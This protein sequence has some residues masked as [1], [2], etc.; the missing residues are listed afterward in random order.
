MESLPSTAVHCSFL[1]GRGLAGGKVMQRA[2]G[3]SPRHRN[4]IFVTSFL[5]LAALALSARAAPPTAEEREPR[6]LGKAK[7]G[8]RAVVITPEG[9][10]VLV[11]VGDGDA[12]VWDCEKGREVRTFEHPFGFQTHALA[13]APDGRHAAL[14]CSEGA[15]SLRNL[16]SGEVIRD[17]KGH[18]GLIQCLAF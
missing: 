18:Q 7:Y 1:S 14:G 4:L 9:R 5:F 2:F 10:R 6:L 16:E 3:G 15:F 12:A 8:I 11:A 13:V 17:F